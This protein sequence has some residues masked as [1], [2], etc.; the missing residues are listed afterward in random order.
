MLSSLNAGGTT[1]SEP[2]GAHK[3]A[4]RCPV[5][6]HLE[7]NRFGINSTWLGKWSTNGEAV[8]ERAVNEEAIVLLADV[9]IEPSMYV[10][11]LT[12]RPANRASRY[13]VT[14][15]CSQSDVS[16]RLSLLRGIFRA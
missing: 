15:F 3:K 13:S 5:G 1:A 4:P 6:R 9:L 2:V 10:S 11:S 14:N 12:G 7:P 8:H 16:T